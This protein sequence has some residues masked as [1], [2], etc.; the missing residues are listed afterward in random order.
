MLA[1]LDAI[2]EAH[3]GEVTALGRFQVTHNRQLTFR[4][5]I[6]TDGIACVT[7]GLKLRPYEEFLV[8]VEPS[9]LFPPLVDVD[10]LRFLNHAHVLQGQ[11]LCLYLDPAREWD[12]AKGFG[13]FIDRLIDWLTDAAGGKFDAQT[14][15]YHAVGGVLHAGSDAPTVVIRTGPAP[16]K[17][18][19]H[20]WLIARSGHR[21]DLVYDPPDDDGGSH[22]PVVQ[23][24]APLP[25]GAG[26]TLRG[27]LATAEDPYLGLPAPGDTF[28]GARRTTGLAAPL[29]TTLG[30]SA[31][32]KPNGSPQGIVI[33]VPHPVGGPPHLLAG[34]IPEQGADRL[35]QLVKTSSPRKW[36]IDINPSDVGPDIELEWW[37]VSDDRQEVTTRRDSTRPTAAFS[38]KRVHLWG[39][40]GLGSW[41]AEYLVRAAVAEIALCDPGTIS[42]GLLVRQNYVEHD[43]GNSKVEALAERLRAINDQVTVT[44]HEAMAPAIA[45]MAQVDLIIDCT[46]SIAIER[47]L[48]GVADTPGRPILA[49]MA[50]DI[51]T[52]TIGLLTVSMPP[53]DAGPLTLDRRAGQIVQVEATLE[54]FR[55]LWREDGDGSEL[56]PTRGCSAPTFHGSSADLAGVAASLTSLLATH[57]GAEQPVSGSHLVSL[58]HGEAGPLHKFIAA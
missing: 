42:R 46:V 44:A 53:N 22:V 35:R 8:T 57:L 47:L 20:G 40:G 56:I 16:L 3:P 12:P 2:A 51:S 39:C 10:H 27:L 28:R 26:S 33:A 30:A 32:R 23:L 37:R 5:R 54:A 36:M 25:L 21:F 4:L 14:A 24:D 11:R 34:N 43:V 19:Q 6:R 41:V 52:G 1:D 31:I 50:T 58:P 7:G 49:Q 29:L 55:G 15:L 9:D 45:E 18:A 38:G 13:G 48:D 17:R